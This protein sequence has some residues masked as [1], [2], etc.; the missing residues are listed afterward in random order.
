MT[1]AKVLMAERHELPFAF[2]ID[3]LEVRIQIPVLHLRRADQRDDLVDLGFQVRITSRS[4]RVGCALQPLVDVGI[5]PER[6]AELAGFF[7]GRDREIVNG[8][9]FDQMPPHGVERASV[10]DFDA[11][12]PERIVDPYAGDGKRGQRMLPG[13]VGGEN[14]GQKE[15]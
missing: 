1:G 12:R 11:W 6:P 4:E 7:A 5:A 15:R 9:C 10:V 14:G 2:R 13:G 3:Q 8:P